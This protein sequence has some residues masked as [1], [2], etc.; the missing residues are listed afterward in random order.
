GVKPSDDAGCG[1]CKTSVSIG[2]ATATLACVS[3]PDCPGGAGDGTVGIMVTGNNLGTV[4]YL[5]SNGANTSSISGLMSGA[6]SVTVTYGPEI[7]GVNKCSKT[8]TCI[9]VEADPVDFTVM[10]TNVICNG[11]NN[12]KIEV[13]PTSGMAN[14]IV[15][16]TGEDNQTSTAIGTKLTFSG[17]APGPYTITV[18]D[19]NGCITTKTVTLTEP[20]PVTITC[21]SDNTSCKGLSDGKI[22]VTSVTSDVGGPYKVSVDQIAGGNND[23]SESTQAIP[24]ET[25]VGKGTYVIT[26]KDKN[27]CIA[28]CTT[29]VKDGFT[30][31][32][33]CSITQIACFGGKGTIT[34]TASGK[35]ADGS[36]VASTYDYVL[37]GAASASN[38]TGIFTGLSAGTYTVTATKTGNSGCSVACTG[39]VIVEPAQ[40]SCNITGN[41]TVCPNA[42]ITFSGPAGMTNYIWSVT[43]ATFTNNGSSIDVTAPATGSFEVK[44]ITKKISSVDNTTLCESSECSKTVNVTVPTCP[45]IAPRTVC[46][47]A[48]N[49]E[50]DAGSGY[51]NIVWSTS[52]TKISIA[53]GQGTHKPKFNIA[54]TALGAYTIT[55]K[56]NQNGCPVSCDF[57][58]TVDPLPTVVLIPEQPVCRT[59][60]SGKISVVASGGTQPYV[61]IIRQNSPTGTIITPTITNQTATGLTYNGLTAG[62]YYVE[63]IDKGGLGCSS[64]PGEQI[65]TVQNPLDF[66]LTLD[67]ENQVAGNVA[68][69]LTN[70]TGGAAA[71]NGHEYQVDGTTGAWINLVNPILLPV[72]SGNYT[73][74][75]REKGVNTGC[76][77][78]GKVINTTCCKLEGVCKLTTPSQLT[79]CDLS[80]VPAAKTNPTDVFSGVTFCKE[81]RIKVTTTDGGSLCGT[82]LTRTYTYLLYDDVI[83]NNVFD[84]GQEP[85]ISGI[86]S[87]TYTVK[88]PELSCNAPSDYSIQETCTTQNISSLFSTWKNGFTYTGGC[89]PMVRYL[90]SIN[91]EA[92]V[93]YQS[94]ANISAPTFCGGKVK[95]KILVKDACTTEKMCMSTFEVA[96]RSDVTTTAPKSTIK[97]QCDLANDFSTWKAL[98]SASGGCSPIIKYFVSIDGGN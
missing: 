76:D 72:N 10:P 24:Y 17:L 37:S 91:D 73:I 94:I 83:D 89:S 71:P 95:I 60:P 43:G 74:Y 56:A 31:A 2:K 51:T 90:V 48:Q 68:V 97:D 35:D 46:A 28:R 5:W 36:P 30:P 69:N 79:G 26:V 16:V 3:T 19:A 84:E 38:T 23:I 41:T 50:Y 45:V 82:G 4:K 66:T 39:N 9:V 47:G 78:Y 65:L 98:F 12:G 52:D 93:E 13:T 55:F 42:K 59:P 63:V 22:K 87:E 6:Y 86:C 81:A 34:A 7:N 14:F 27:G 53:S 15:D 8:E 70:I 40:L 75:L 54:S 32:I 64:D 57:T 80:V 33:N 62:T 11:A 44:L 58:L 49:V 92:E 1:Y 88:A 29:I 61:F 18:T 77:P 20:N 21:A 25:T 85:F 67:C 96:K